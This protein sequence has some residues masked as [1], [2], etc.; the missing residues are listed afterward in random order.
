MQ[1]NMNNIQ[2]RTNGQCHITEKLISGTSEDEFD[3]KEVQEIQ[4]F[5]NK[6]SLMQWN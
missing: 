1:V 3:L 6:F 5:S 4:Y 2:V